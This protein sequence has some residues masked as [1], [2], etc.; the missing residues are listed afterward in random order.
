MLNI[1][2]H[3]KNANQ[4]HDE[5]SPH[6]CQNGYYQKTTNKCWLGWGEKGI[7]THCWWDASWLSQYRKHLE[8]PQKIKN[9]MTIQ[10]SNSTAGYLSK[11]NKNANSKRYASLCSLHNYSQQPRYESSPSV[12]QQVSG[13]RCGVYVCI[14]NAIL[15]G[16]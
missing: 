8:F 15:L 16:H 7:L 2:Y 4:N 5:I 9:G 13:W 1:T 12:H 3:Q 14:R 6:I 11:E 10:S